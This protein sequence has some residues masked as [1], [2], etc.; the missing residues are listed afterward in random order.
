MRMLP[1]ERLPNGKMRFFSDYLFENSITGHRVSYDRDNFRCDLYPDGHLAIYEGT[2]YDMGTG[3][4][5]TPA[6]IVASAEHDAGCRMTDHGYLPWAMRHEFDKQL[7]RRLSEW[8]ATVSRFWRV[9]LVMTY[10]NL[11]ARWRREK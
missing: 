10:S 4:V 5:D 11:V 1:I 2:V 9:P 7:W 3:A 6:M 8:G